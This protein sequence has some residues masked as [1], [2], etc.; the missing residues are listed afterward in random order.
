MADSAQSK[1]P[2]F[3]KPTDAKR[4]D[5]LGQI[6]TGVYKQLLIFLGISIILAA[7]FYIYLRFGQVPPPTQ[8]NTTAPPPNTN[9]LNQTKTKFN[10]NQQRKNDVVIVNSAL[11]SYFLTNEKAPK[12]LKTLVPKDLPQL[13]TD[14]ET[15]EN[16]I[17]T[18]AED[19]KTW[20]ISATLSDG[21]L[22]EVEGP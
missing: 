11:K 16:Y 13:P 14:P 2:E 10:L 21:T 1:D 7:G 18:P 20:K 6:D 5:L 8:N 15:N 22:F 4:G 12:E 9:Q 17:Y 3:M 19:L